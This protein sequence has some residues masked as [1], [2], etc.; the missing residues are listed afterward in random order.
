M[1]E[2]PADCVRVGNYAKL[3]ICMN[4]KKPITMLKLQTVL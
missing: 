3:K 4:N 2:S 1:R